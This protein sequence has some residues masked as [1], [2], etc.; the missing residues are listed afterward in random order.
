MYDTIFHFSN[1][2]YS[3]VIKL[4][5]KDLEPSAGILFVCPEDGSLLL[6]QRGKAMS[7]PGK[8][9]IAGGRSD[10]S[11]T[12]ELTAVREA[13]EELG[14]LPANK[15]LIAKKSLNTPELD[16]IYIIYVYSI[17]KEEKDRWSKEIHIDFESQDIRWF[18]ISKIPSN[19]HLDLTWARS[20]L[21]NNT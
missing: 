4:A 17:S 20:F 3:N 12:P 19:T 6:L 8:W 7:S 11:E 16:N 14:C 15:K 13:T 5:K 21:L 10:G 2:F 9:D 18:P 1:V